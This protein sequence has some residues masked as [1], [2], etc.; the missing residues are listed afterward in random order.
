MACFAPLLLGVAPAF[1]FVSFGQELARKW[2]DDPNAGT[3]VIVTWGFIPEGTG[4]DPD[5]LSILARA[6]YR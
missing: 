4:L 2:C 1:M 6:V 3:G 5:F